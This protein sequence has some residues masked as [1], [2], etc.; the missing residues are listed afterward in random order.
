MRAIQVAH[1][2]V[3]LAHV[4]AE[5]LRD[6]PDQRQHREGDERQPPVHPDHHRHD[7]DQRED[8]A[9]D[10]HDAG[11]EQLVQD[12]HVGRDARHQPADGI[13]VVE[14]QVEPL[15]VSVDLHPQVEH[16]PLAGH[17]HH[18]GLHVL[19]HERSGKR[20]EVQRGDERQ[21]R[22]CRAPECSGR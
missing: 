11:R 9:E 16:D 19:E 21:A 1:R 17:L 18:P 8:V 3:R 5:P 10:R 2:A 6:E 15:Q 20:R 12:V 13:P 4:R 14:A 22:R 7:A